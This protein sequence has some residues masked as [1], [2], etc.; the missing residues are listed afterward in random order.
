MAA[1]FVPL[2]KKA[3]LKTGAERKHMDN[4]EFRTMKMETE[5]MDSIAVAT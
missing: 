1:E 3:V 5:T 2:T 4:I